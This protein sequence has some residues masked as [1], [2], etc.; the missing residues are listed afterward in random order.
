MILPV[1]CFAPAKW[2]VLLSSEHAI[3]FLA[4]QIFHVIYLP[5]EMFMSQ[6]AAYFD[7]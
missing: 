2:A 1:G 7:P 5:C 4:S 3:Y 6:K